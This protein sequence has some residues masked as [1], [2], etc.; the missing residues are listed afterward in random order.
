MYTKLLKWRW[1]VVG[2]VIVLVTILLKAVFTPERASQTSDDLARDID[3]PAI[4]TLRNDQDYGNEEK[5]L[6]AEITPSVEKSGNSERDIRISFSDHNSLPEEF[7]GLYETDLPAL[8]EKL[9][10]KAAN[11]ETGLYDYYYHSVVKD[12][13]GVPR[14]PDSLEAAIMELE[15][16]AISGVVGSNGQ[17]IDMTER[18]RE[19][20]ETCRSV[21]LDDISGVEE[22]LIVSAE[23][24]FS[25]AKM[26]VVMTAS[27]LDPN[28]DSFANDRDRVVRYLDEARND[29]HPQAVLF[30]SKLHQEGENNTVDHRQAAIMHNEIMKKL[31]TQK[32]SDYDL[33]LPSIEATSLD[34][35]DTVSE[36]QYLK[37]KISADNFY[38]ERCK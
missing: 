33:S 32:Y 37:A 34:L 17:Y 24:G 18:I 21:N 11:D 15:V 9:K 13:V 22:A 30:A 7:S 8:I 38:D 35:K 20:Y 23:K 16:N 19:S 12:C 36:A 26:A 6:H 25:P 29:C 31:I 10:S 14:S 1:G 4:I 2:A 5:V 3:K 27:T 28:N